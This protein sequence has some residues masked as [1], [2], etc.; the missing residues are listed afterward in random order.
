[1]A[2][3]D[4]VEN[5]FFISLGITF[6]LILLLI[7]HFKQ[8]ISSV[9]R[10]GDTMY[11]LMT[12]IVK[13][14]KFVKGVNSYY[15]S[16]FRSTGQSLPGAGGAPLSAEPAG[17]PVENGVDKKVIH[18]PSEGETKSTAIQVV[19]HLPCEEEEEAEPAVYSKIVVSDDD[20]GSES[21]SESDSE[22][23]VEEESVYSEDTDFVE[24][25]EDGIALGEIEL[26]WGGGG[27]EDYPAP[28]PARLEEVIL[29]EE[30]PLEHPA[31]LVSEISV[32]T[33]EEEPSSSS[34]IALPESVAN[35]IADPATEK[36]NEK[37]PEGN[38]EIYR[39]MNITQLRSIAH[40]VGI[41]GDLA[42]MK[43]NEIIR[44]LERISDAKSGIV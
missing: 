35:P 4:F 42:K 30:F 11:E 33:T 3:F 31:V 39:K 37:D 43:K 8:R 38:R 29:P 22:S 28:A 1:M 12:N 24:E 13:E 17:C 15:E 41:E 32:P 25:F 16:F 7:Y 44:L 26:E 23:G 2:L 10:K 20:S 40:A 34:S 21:D 19:K 5:F 36:G 9:E 27:K 14:L 6:A 18:F